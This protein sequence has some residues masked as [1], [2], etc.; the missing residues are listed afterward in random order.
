MASA[1]AESSEMSTESRLLHLATREVTVDL[2]RG[3]LCSGRSRSCLKQ[4]Q[5]GGEKELGTERK[6]ILKEFG[7]KRQQRMRWLLE[8]YVATKSILLLFLLY[9]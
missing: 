4:V 8:V 1:G 5:D 3:A 2:M 7:C 6:I 9:S